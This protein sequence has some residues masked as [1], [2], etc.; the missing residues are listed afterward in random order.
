MAKT[1]DNKSG[2]GAD[3]EAIITLK[4]V[5]KKFGDNVVLDN[6]SLTI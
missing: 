2:G 1:A 5:T 3:G 6:L 4:N